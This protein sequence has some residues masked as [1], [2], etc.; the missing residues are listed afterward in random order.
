MVSFFLLFNA[1]QITSYHIW[2]FLLSKPLHAMNNNNTM[3]HLCSSSFT[4]RALLFLFIYTLY[5]PY[6]TR[7]DLMEA[8]NNNNWFT[9]VFFYQRQDIDRYYE[10]MIR[11]DCPE[12]SGKIKKNRRCDNNEVLTHI[13]T[14][15]V[16]I[17]YVLVSLPPT[18][19]SC[20]N[21]RANQNSEY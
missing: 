14:D 6:Y 8:T 15:S 18:L 9:M 10:R 5:S 3:C 7:A 16:R 2:L 17:P 20:I 12:F 19:C 11:S 1:L 13:P 21:V 4:F